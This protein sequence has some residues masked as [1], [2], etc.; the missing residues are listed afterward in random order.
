MPVLDVARGVLDLEHPG[1]SLEALT[2]ELHRDTGKSFDRL[3]VHVV[4]CRLA[5]VLHGYL[6]R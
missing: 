4:E 5:P 6:L 1:S 2:E 3:P